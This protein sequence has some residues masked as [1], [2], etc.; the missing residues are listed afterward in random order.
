MLI[1]RHS[2][3]VTALLRSCGV[4]PRHY[5]LLMDL[6]GKLSERHEFMT[7]LGRS[8]FALKAMAWWYFALSGFVVLVSLFVQPSPAQYL[9]I[10]LALTALVLLTLLVS[11]TNN[12]LVNP[13][14][15]LVLA[16]QPIE[17]ATY[18]AAKLSHLGRILLY[19]VPALNGAPALAG[20]L[21]RA[22][23]FYP[24]LHMLA[25]FALGLVM[26]LFCCAGF[27]WLIRFVPA[28]RL[29]AVG[30][31]T[32]LIVWMAFLA[33]PQAP[34]FLKR[35]HFSA[36][37][38]GPGVPRVALG[39]AVTL[40]VVGSVVFGLRSLS[41]DYMLRVSSIVHGASSAKVQSRKW[42]RSSAI[43]GWLGGQLGRAGFE[44]VSKMMTH[45]WQFLRQVVPLAPALV[46]AGVAMALGLRVPP[47]SSRFTSMHVLPHAFGFMLFLICNVLAYGNDYKGAWLFQ[48]VPA[49]AWERFAQ[50]VFA[51]LWSRFIVIPHLLLLALLTWFWGV[52][53]AALFVAYSLA[54]AS[55]YLALELRLVEGVP[56]SKQP[57]VSQ[58]AMLL[59]Y[60]LM[61]GL[62]AALLVGLQYFILFRSPASALA[63]TA[64]VAVG[65]YYLTRSSLR[66]L[67]SAM[68]Y[69]LGL[70]SG[71]SSFL[72][73]EAG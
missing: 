37:L 71:E 36:W 51:G 64:I 59:P 70:V 28:P 14:E 69:N 39:A 30:N 58:G 66:S 13:V 27:G 2:S 45:D 34:R 6:F 62:G 43:S 18:T 49:G 47:S 55:F 10:F 60:M 21:L 16:H 8:G 17:G 63:A 3:L 9:S 5:W 24:F 68:R 32:E 25:A 19:V 35:V 26:A 61:G 54:V 44:F 50:G 29:K 41:V 53:P 56:F 38:P 12:S 73:K 52:G 40:L 33:F 11:E 48:L 65:A 4:N 22:P 57:Q 15:G 7:Q 67:S 42:R 1:T 31:W 72:Y 23:W 46:I 20:L